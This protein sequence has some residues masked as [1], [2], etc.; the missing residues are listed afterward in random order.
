MFETL[1][2]LRSGNERQQRALRVIEEHK[3]FSILSPYDPLLAGTIPIGVDIDS[4]DLDVL[5]YWRNREMFLEDMIEHFSPQQHFRLRA[6]N[7]RGRDSII[8]N[9]RLE[10]FEIEI[11]GQN[12][13]SR[14]QEGFRHLMIEHKL[15]LEHGEELREEVIRLKKEGMKTEPAFA[16]ALKLDGDPYEALLRFE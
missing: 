12:Q 6:V 16:K 10:E 7:I 1:D 13:P 14:E 11:F 4:S 8:V 9:F 3:L 15:L 5:C 2:Y